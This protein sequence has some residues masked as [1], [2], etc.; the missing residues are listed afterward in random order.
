MQ[1]EMDQSRIKQ[2]R[3]LFDIASYV[4]RQAKQHCK[5][6]FGRG[7]G[8]TARTRGRS[9]ALMNSIR[10]ARVDNSSVMVTAGGNG[11]PYAAIHEHGGV[12]KPVNVNWLTIPRFPKYVGR[13][14]REFAL[15]FEQR[16]NSKVAWLV[17]DH[18]NYAYLL[19]KRVTIPARPYLEPAVNDVSNNTVLMDRLKLIFGKSKIPWEIVRL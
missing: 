18:R 14:A 11:V 9:G 1:N 7:I 15:H 2:E 13:R 12:V 19:V 6:N 3:L 16:K 8:R 4:T 10:M 17:D 5:E